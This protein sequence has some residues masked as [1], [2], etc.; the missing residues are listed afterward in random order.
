MESNRDGQ[1]SDERAQIALAKRDPHAF[2]P[3]YV[4]YFDPVYR[5]IL[6]RVN[7]D[8]ERAADA[9]SQTFLKAL[10]ALPGYHAGS[11]AGWL[12]TIA[13]NTV[14]DQARRAK[15][16]TRLPELWEPIDREP[17]PEQIAIDRSVEEELAA[18]LARL[19]PDQRE[20]I[21]LRLA[22][23]SGQEIADHL[24]RNLGAIR[25]MQFR[26]LSQLRRMMSIESNSLLDGL[27][28]VITE[29]RSHG[30]A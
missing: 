16:E 11:F 23:M 9:T 30:I 21:E 8:R 14:I 26:A 4:Q 18:L 10:A 27:S 19:T 5:Y 22:G 17:S 12:F 29:E 15:P 3:L 20:V 2:A 25:S 24:G 28:A 1:L 13:R 6:R 7:G